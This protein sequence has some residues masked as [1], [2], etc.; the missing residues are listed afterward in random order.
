MQS[1]DS[2]TT[3]HQTEPTDAVDNTPID[4]V[5]LSAMMKIQLD[6]PTEGSSYTLLHKFL[7]ILESVLEVYREDPQRVVG[8]ISPHALYTLLYKISVKRQG[9]FSAYALEIT[10]N[11]N[12][13]GLLYYPTHPTRHGFEYRAQYSSFLNPD[14]FP[15][16]ES[17]RREYLQNLLYLIESH[18]F[19]GIPAVTVAFLRQE[20]HRLPLESVRVEDDHRVGIDDD[21]VLDRHEDDDS[22]SNATIFSEPSASAASA[23]PT[24]RRPAPIEVSS[25]DEEITPPVESV[26]DK[27]MAREQ[28]IRKMTNAFTTGSIQELV[29]LLNS[30]GCA[31]T[32]TSAA[33]K[34]ASAAR[35]ASERPLTAG[36]SSSSRPESSFFARSP[37]HEA[38]D[39]VCEWLNSWRTSSGARERFVT[40]IR[41]DRASFFETLLSVFNQNHAEFNRRIGQN[42]VL[43]QIILNLPIG[44]SLNQFMRR[45]N[46]FQIKR[47]KDTTLFVLHA[48]HER[49]RRTPGE[50]AQIQPL[51]DALYQDA[52]AYHST[53]VSGSHHSN[54]HFVI[55]E[56]EQLR[57]RLGLPGAAPIHRP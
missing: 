14:C 17:S 7:S 6:T 25:D 20:L 8:A 23:P 31:T 9:D 26:R 34:P 2:R 50:A 10:R 56:L 24:F 54:H 30:L 1:K 44:E 36:A 42:E 28:A 47:S 32:P 27:K 3:S 49:Q 18:V 22:I 45:L 53:K 33:K 40:L 35:G 19:V 5:E 57:D 51:Y 15:Q 52:H 38:M 41:Q 12:E 43:S 55:A 29:D 21:Q 11:I 13:V 16:E 4:L 37:N 39:L 46:S 48:L